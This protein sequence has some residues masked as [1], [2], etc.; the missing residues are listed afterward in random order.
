MHRVHADLL[1]HR[2]Q[3]RRGDDDQ[4][5]HIHEGAEQQQH[6]VDDEKDD[7]RI[8][9]RRGYE[10]G[11]LRRRFQNRQRIAEGGRSTDDEQHHGRDL[12]RLDRRFCEFAPAERAIDQ[13][14]DKDCVDDR[15]G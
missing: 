12:H 13:R 1:H 5:R 6:D 9:R 14:A 8:V 11:E 10:I 2:Q 15:D 3:D 7:D 4:R